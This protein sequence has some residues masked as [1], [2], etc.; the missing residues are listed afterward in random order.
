MNPF[1]DD[2]SFENDPQDFAMPYR[3]YG[4][5]DAEVMF[6][7]YQKLTKSS[8]GLIVRLGMYTR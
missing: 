4:Q 8:Y 1:T 2:Q 6:D 5:T 7:R 3:L